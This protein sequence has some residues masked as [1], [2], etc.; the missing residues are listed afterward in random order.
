MLAD[1]MACNPRNA[2]PGECSWGGCGCVL[3]P[4]LSVLC[5]KSVQQLQEEPEYLW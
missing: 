4:S 2:Y 3:A 1:D 5:S